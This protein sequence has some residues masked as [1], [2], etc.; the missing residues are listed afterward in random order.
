MSTNLKFR[1]PVACLSKAR[2]GVLATSMVIASSIAVPAAHI[3]FPAAALAQTQDD[4]SLEQTVTDS[5]DVVPLGTQKV[6]DHGHADLGPVVDSD[7]GETRF[8]VRDDSEFPPKWRHLSDT[9]F[10]VDDS[11]KQTLPEEAQSFDFT[12]AQPGSQVWVIPQ[13]EVHGVPWLG[14]NTQNP[15]LTKNADRGITLEFAGHEGDGQFSLFL[16]N[17]GFAEP[18]V[19]W[20][21]AKKESQ[22]MWV[23]LNTHTHANWVFTQPGVHKVAV[24]A[25]IPLLD[26][27]TK[28]FTEVLTFAVGKDALEEAK[29]AQW[30]GE[31]LPSSTKGEEKGASASSTAK[32]AP[33]SEK[34]S[35]VAVWIFVAMILIALGFVV[36]GLRM[37]ASAKKRKETAAQ[38]GQR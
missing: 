30:E 38:N 1:I 22:P 35:S 4:P 5:E 7:S 12:G 17:G 29:S 18:Q 36:A 9:I 23:D 6:F 14:W 33:A 8:L 10:L 3:A 25:L 2:V 28:E 37:R 15:T 11:A 19:L 16:Q 32:D 20:T 27:T 24:R 34:S 21:S 31:Y 26:G 13:S